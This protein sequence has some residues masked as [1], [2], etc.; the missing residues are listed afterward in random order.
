M[1]FGGS[2]ASQ[3][4]QDLFL[5]YVK[6][7]FGF[8][9]HPDIITIVLPKVEQK[10]VPSLICNNYP[11]YSYEISPDDVFTALRVYSMLVLL[12]GD[13][14]Q[15]VSSKE[16]NIKP[17]GHLI[18]IGSPVT[19]PFSF[20]VLK[21]QYYS[22]GNGKE[23][24]DILA[25][26]GNRYFVRLDSD[27]DSIPLSKKNLI[28]DYSLITKRSMHGIV[29]VVLAGC[30]AYGQMA[31]WNILKNMDFYEKV[32]PDAEGKDFQI[33]VEVDVEGRAC[34]TWRILKTHLGQAVGIPKQSPLPLK[35]FTWLHLSDLHFRENDFNSNIVLK[36]LLQDVVYLS[37]QKNL[38]PDF[39]VVTGDITFSNK[40]A[41]YEQAGIFFDRLLKGVRLSKKRLFIVPG[42]HD[43]DRNATISEILAGSNR[44]NV[45][46]ILASKEI[47]HLFFKRLHNYAEFL[48]KYFG[49]MLKFDDDNYFYVKPLTIGGKK[50]AI[51]GLN[52]VWS[53]V[54]DKRE[55]ILIGELQVRKA[56]EQAKRADICIALVHHPFSCLKDFDR[57]DSYELLSNCCDFI[58]H[59]HLHEA[60]VQQIKSSGTGAIIIGAGTSYGGR[61]YPNTY[62]FVQLN[63]EPGK[64]ILRRYSDATTG[65]WA[66]DTLTYRGAKEDGMIPFNYGVDRTQ[67]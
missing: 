20:D 3:K 60:K 25:Q 35:T 49:T 40:P 46:Q 2:I 32:L 33:L 61:E 64:V 56:L 65:F 7:F 26:D 38:K 47:R 24:H 45:N 62:N 34:K 23:D 22:F 29:E 63:T 9:D 12:Y 58:L 39:I 17:L 8:G 27:D 57:N 55:R 36:E 44:D 42:N 50:L 41:E 67:C 30:R 11:M 52:S 28:K 5:N 15:V 37:H 10:R 19:N 1:K 53:C 59:G 43:V 14:V 66:K 13:R 18:L 48:N 21:D 6:S 54:S 31:F 51:M 4:Q 16:Q